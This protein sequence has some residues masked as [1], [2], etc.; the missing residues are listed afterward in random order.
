MFTNF[1]IILQPKLQGKIQPKTVTH[2]K[3]NAT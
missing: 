3:L 2:F 1:A